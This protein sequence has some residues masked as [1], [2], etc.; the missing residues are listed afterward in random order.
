LAKLREK[1]GA[2]RYIES[3][4][5]A[6]GYFTGSKVSG[7][8]VENTSKGLNITGKCKGSE[9]KPY[10]VNITVEQDQDKIES[11]GWTGSCTCE[12]SS[13]KKKTCSHQVSLLLEVIDKQ[14]AQNGK[15]TLKSKS[16]VS[17]VESTM[18]SAEKKKYAK[19][20]EELS[21]KKNQEI[22][23]MLKYNGM[24]VTGT[25]DEL[26]DRVAEAMTMGVVGK[27]NVCGGGR[28]KFTDGLWV[29]SG[30]MD[31]TDYQNCSF[32]DV[33]VKRTDWEVEK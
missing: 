13:V 17:D 11:D 24:K 32:V 3:F 18:T 26:V 23:E 29:C 30:Y 19:F 22:Q 4:W 10:D 21:G 16:K 7:V 6:Y 5:K 9:K 33:E 28:P 25:K 1:L 8:E 2:T 27:C 31:D 15:S 12:Q 14:R 20:Q